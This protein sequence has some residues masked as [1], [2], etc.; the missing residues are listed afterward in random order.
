MNKK[1]RTGLI[2]VIITIIV[3]IIVV[4]VSN[5]E[6]N[7]FS[8]IGSAFS[9]IVMPIQNGFSNL[10]HSISGDSTFF[11]DM[12]SIKE[13]NQ[14]LQAENASM[15]QSLR[16]LEILKAENER[17]VQYMGLK[18]KYASLS[19]MPAS[20]I[21]KDNSNYSNVIIINVGSNDGIKENM[22]VI[23]NEGLVGHVISVTNTTAKVQ[24]LLDTSSAVSSIAG[25]NRDSLIVRGTLES[26]TELRGNTILTTATILVGDKVETS[27]LGGIYP[28]G[29][30]IGTIKEIVDTKNLSNRYVTIEPAVN[31]D[32]LST[33]LVI[34]N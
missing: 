18:E 28:N 21:N 30:T 31:F 1:K 27:G 26:K 34:T 33:V 8:S 20:V 25:S 3:L 7:S 5:S 17:L 9:V 23:S 19:T 14:K 15:Q 24:T 6:M 29:I 2:G 4:V 10:S 22:P 13:E 11:S 16:E 32:K 12:D